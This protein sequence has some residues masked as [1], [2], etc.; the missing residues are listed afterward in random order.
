M[1]AH[2]TAVVI[3]GVGGQLFHHLAPAL[4]RLGRRQKVPFQHGA[5]VELQT[6]DRHFRQA[7]LEADHLP[8]FGGTQTAAQ[9]SRRLGE[10]GL[11]GWRTTTT[12]GTA[13]AMEQG[14]T[15]IVGFGQPHQR[16]HGGVLGPASGHHARILGRIRVTDHHVLTALNVAAIPVHREQALHHGG[17]CHQVILSFKQ[18]GDRHAERAACLF[19]QQLYRQHIGRRTGHGDDV[20]AKRIGVVLGDDP[21]GIQRLAY[22]GARLPVVGDQRAAGVELI[23]QEGLFVIFAPLG[24]VTQTQI[25]GQLGEDQPVTLA[26]LTD[27]QLDQ[28]D[29]EAGD[30]AQHVQQHAIGD[31]AHAASVQ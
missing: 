17:A 29:A 9:G 19:E 31:I 22:L 12:D 24:V 27:I 2:D 1:T 4:F 7:E 14:E 18:R 25:A 23:E 21:A 3:A 26:I 8:L 15:D 28:M 20:D 30:L 11:M 16:L 6:L 5:G 13:T 10:N